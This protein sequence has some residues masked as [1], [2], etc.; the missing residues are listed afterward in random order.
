MR[1]FAKLSFLHL[2]YFQLAI[3]ICACNGNAATVTF[4]QFNN[5]NNNNT[6]NLFKKDSAPKP[7]NSSVNAFWNHILLCN[8]MAFRH[9]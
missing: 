2:A 7:L 6:I 5:N 8:A 3:L 1:V 9:F 4:D